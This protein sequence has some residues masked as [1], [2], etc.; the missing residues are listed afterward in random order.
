MY[1]KQYEEWDYFS[2]AGLD[3][4]LEE[5]ES[6]TSFLLRF[7]LSHPDL[8]TTIVGTAN[9]KHFKENIETANKGILPKEIYSEA[10][11]R[12]NLI[13]ISPS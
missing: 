4:L 1:K 3:D 6:K 2:Q 12:L 13:G 11:R 7:T 10:K 8:N 9:P 5:G